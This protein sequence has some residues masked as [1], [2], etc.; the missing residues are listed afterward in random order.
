MV[1][2]SNLYYGSGFTDGSSD[3]PAH[4]REIVDW[5]LG[6]GGLLQEY[7]TFDL[8]VGKSIGENVRV[9]VTALNLSNRRLLPNVRRNPLR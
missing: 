2:F 5:Q 7:T 1:N 9:S 8:S 4:L 3:V 6:D